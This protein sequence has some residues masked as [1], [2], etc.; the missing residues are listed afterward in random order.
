MPEWPIARVR[1]GPARVEAA[2]QRDAGG[3]AGN[4][5]VRLA[6]RNRSRWIA[7]AERYERELER[8]ERKLNATLTLSD[9]PFRCRRPDVGRPRPLAP[10]AS[11]AVRMGEISL[12][13]H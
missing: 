11:I 2:A 9:R 6:A 12:A 4:G 5:P 3:N 7:D 8:Y 1:N 10:Q 13:G